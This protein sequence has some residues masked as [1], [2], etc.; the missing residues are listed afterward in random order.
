M[1]L[2]GLNL[3]IVL[4]LEVSV[5]LNYTFTKYFFLYSTFDFEGPI[6]QAKGFDIWWAPY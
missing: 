1:I 4:N 6:S 3:L 5:Y 2:N